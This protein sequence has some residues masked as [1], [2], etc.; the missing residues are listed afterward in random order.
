MRRAEQLDLSGM[1]LLADEASTCTSPPTTSRPQP[2]WQQRGHPTPAASVAA[3]FQVFVT[4]RASIADVYPSPALAPQDQLLLFDSLASLPTH[5]PAHLAQQQQTSAAPAALQA[6]AEPSMQA[7]EAIA[8]QLRAELGL[9]LFGFDVVI[10]DSVQLQPGI[11]AR[12]AVHELIVID[13]NY[14]PNYRGGADTPALFRTA[15]RQCWEKHQK[16][17]PGNNH[18][19][20]L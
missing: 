8:A 3:L 12:S 20:R 1:F 11:S 15:L 2:L 17:Y 16:C 19:H 9:T 6:A 5:L 18:D 13:V 10:P 4:P 7:L 14:F